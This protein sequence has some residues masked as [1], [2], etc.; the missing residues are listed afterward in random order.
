MHRD[1]NHAAPPLGDTTAAYLPD[2]PVALL[3]PREAVA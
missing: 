3:L 2:D 1:R